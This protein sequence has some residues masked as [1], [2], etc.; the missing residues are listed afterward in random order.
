M[1]IPRA[2]FETHLFHIACI[3]F[4]RPSGFEVADSARLL[5]EKMLG[6]KSYPTN[7]TTTRKHLPTFSITQLPFRAR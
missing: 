5:P 2:E 7:T 4:P 3:S 6:V 1:N